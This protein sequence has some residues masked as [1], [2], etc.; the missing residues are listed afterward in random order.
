MAE[1]GIHA[2]GVPGAPEDHVAAPVWNSQDRRFADFEVGDKI[3]SVRRTISEARPMQF[4]SQV[5][6]HYP[7]VSDE[8]FAAEAGAFGK[9]RVAGAKVFSCGLDRAAR[10]C[11][12]S[13]SYG[14]DRLRFIASAI[15]GDTICTIRGNLSKEVKDR[16][17]GKVRGSYLVFKG[18]GAHVL[19]CERS[20]TA[21]H[22]DASRFTEQA[23]AAPEA[24]ARG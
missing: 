4:K 15:I 1:I 2:Q 22:R 16:K 10:N 24:K 21:L 3:R 7:C 5:M 23:D 17:M 13:L 20:T 11:L 8:R 19:N 12:N 14:C 9:R 18:E 6:D